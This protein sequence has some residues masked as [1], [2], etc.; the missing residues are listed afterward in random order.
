MTKEYTDTSKQ[1]PEDKALQ[2]YQQRSFMFGLLSLLT[3]AWLA[4]VGLGFGIAGLVQTNKARA[5]SVAIK[6]TPP[7]RFMPQ[8]ILS[9]LGTIGSVVAMIV[10]LG[11]LLT[12][13]SNLVPVIQNTV[14]T[15]SEYPKAV[16]TLKA[17][18]KDF[19]VSQTVEFG[20]FDIKIRDI[21][22]GYTPLAGEVA[23]PGAGDMYTKF[24]ADV[25]YNASRGASYDR[26]SMDLRS[27]GDALATLKLDGTRCST[28]PTR[29][30]LEKYNA[31]YDETYKEPTTITYVCAGTAS[32]PTHATLDVSYFS[33]VSSIVGTEGMP[34]GDAM[35]TIRF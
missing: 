10:V 5:R 33:K 18:E 32:T 2:S 17:A 3:C 27:W 26:I 6:D 28:N 35:Y 15:S 24:V 34:R 23:Q 8:F 1:A 4:P 25:S 14:K 9:L 19:T 20:P 22:T 16:A 31:P 13:L 12:N 29:D 30:V 7:R 21:Q 11:M